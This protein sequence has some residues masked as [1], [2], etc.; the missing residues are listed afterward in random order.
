MGTYISKCVDMFPMLKL[1][2]QVHRLHVIL[3]EYYSD[4]IWNDRIRSIVEPWWI[5]V[6][7]SENVELHH[8]EYFILNRKQLDDNQYIRS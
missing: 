1:E 4:F 5:F 7:D 6:E 8:S 3:Y 2:A